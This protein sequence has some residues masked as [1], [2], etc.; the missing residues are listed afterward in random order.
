MRSVLA[1]FAG[2][3]VTF[4]YS[5]YIVRYLQQPL[6]RVLPEDH[7]TL[8]YTGITD[9]F[10][11]YMQISV[12]ASVAITFPYLLSQLWRLLSPML[13]KSQRRF[14]GPFILFG[15][16]SFLVGMAFAYFVIIPM[17]YEYLIH[18]GN[19]EDLPLITLTEYF[20]L[21]MKIMLIA[22]IVFELPVVMVLLGRFGLVTH[23]LLSRYRRHAIL[24]IAVVSSIATPS[25]DAVTLAAVMIPM[26]LLYELSIIGVRFTSKP[27]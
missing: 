23:Q 20:S 12:L 25:P 13:D 9:K 1:I 5:D 10:M 8:Y 16:T 17:G 21:T 26:Y 22:A 7:K 11:V 2:W 14:A 18:F 6:L 27:R 24:V 3:C 19:K 4:Y 15:T